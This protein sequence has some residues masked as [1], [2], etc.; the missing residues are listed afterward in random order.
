[1]RLTLFLTLLFTSCWISADAN[2]SAALSSAA[3]QQAARALFD[4][5][6][7]KLAELTQLSSS[8]RDGVVVRDVEFPAT[9][10]ERARV[11]AFVINPQTR[12]ALAAKPYAGI[13]YFHWL[14]ATN[15]NRQE[16]FAEAS[17][18]VKRGAVAV[19]IEG[20]FPWKLPPKDG[21]TDKQRV[22]QEIIDLRRALDLLLAQPGVD[23]Q[24]IAFVGHDYGAMYGAILAG[25]DQRPQSYVLLT[26]TGSFSRWSL[27]YWLAKATPQLKYAYRDALA[28][29]DP[30][31]QIT[32]LAAPAELMLQF[33]KHDEH[34]RH[35]EAEAFAAAVSAPKTVKWYEAQHDLRVKQ[36]DQDRRAWLSKRL[37][38]K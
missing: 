7:N 28:V 6:A 23:P 36:A 27:D 25:V 38:L 1:M 4:Y 11:K 32:H 30:I 13:L 12:G 5:E 17:G 20:Y 33:A 8:L 22:I 18:M 2:P 34:I 16:F 26:P 9:G 14:G 31:K 24:R 29:I 21:A 10:S 37:G 15:S 3:Q 19:L 35:E